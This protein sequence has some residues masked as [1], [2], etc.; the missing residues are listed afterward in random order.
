[1]LSRCTKIEQYHA[2]VYNVHIRIPYNKTHH[3]N[4]SFTLVL[5]LGM[6]LIG[7]SNVNFVHPYPT[8]PP[9]QCLNLHHAPSSHSFSS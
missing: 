7:E 2:A 6:F 3:V 1:M 5:E 8:Y 4:L 9:N